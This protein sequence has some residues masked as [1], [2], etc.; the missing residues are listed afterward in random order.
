MEASG[1]SINHRPSRAGEGVWPPA[2]LRDV[3]SLALLSSFSV[4]GIKTLTMLALSGGRAWLSSQLKDAV[5]HRQSH[6]SGGERTGHGYAS[7]YLTSPPYPGHHPGCPAQRSGHTQW[8]RLP[9][10][11]CS[12]DNGLQAPLLPSRFCQV[13]DQ[14]CLTCLRGRA[15]QFSE[16]DS[17]PTLVMGG[18]SGVDTLPLVLTPKGFSPA[19][20][21][22]LTSPFPWATGPAS[23]S[24]LLR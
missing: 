8:A 3:S 20:H 22:S 21:G 16:D 17:G 15:Q 14:H 5:C 19:G 1:L 4:A 9:T 23:G 12:Q 2:Q 10:Q 11:Y 13:D 24:S 7:A 6:R 18:D